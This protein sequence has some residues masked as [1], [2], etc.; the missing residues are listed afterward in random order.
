VRFSVLGPFVVSDGDIQHDLGGG[1][2]RSLLALL[3]LH[4]NQVVAVDRIG[5]ALWGDDP[6]ASAPALLE[7]DVGRLRE[8]LAEALVGHPCGYGL[9]TPV[10]SVDADDFERLV[11][12]ARNEGPVVAEESLREALAL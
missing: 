3:V 6:P 9:R 7:D 12:R 10:G 11:T 4:R 2:A 5:E 8:L 1:R